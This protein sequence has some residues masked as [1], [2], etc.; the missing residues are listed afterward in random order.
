MNILVIY[1]K[2][3]LTGSF[4]SSIELVKSAIHLKK[5]IRLLCIKEN[6]SDYIPWEDYGLSSNNFIESTRCTILIKDILKS[7]LPQNII[8]SCHSV[9]PLVKQLSEELNVNYSVIV[10]GGSIDSRKSLSA[11]DTY[12]LRQAYKIGCVANH[13]SL[14]IEQNLGIAPIL[15]R[16]S[17]TKACVRNLKLTGANIKLLFVGQLIERKSPDMLR[18]ILYYLN[19]NLG[20][21][22]SITLIGKGP[23][24]D[25][26]LSK[27]SDLAQE[28]T[29][30]ANLQP[31][32]LKKVFIKNDFLVCFSKN[33]GRP[34]VVLEAIAH[35]LIPILSNIP[36]HIEI[37][38]D[39]NQD[40]LFQKGEVGHICKLIKSHHVNQK[41]FVQKINSLQRSALL[42]TSEEFNLGVAQFLTQDSDANPPQFSW[43]LQ[44]APKADSKMDTFRWET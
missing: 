27:I 39:Q 11:K 24:Q 21:K 31:R 43:G 23:E 20:M 37:L 42:E 19:Q 4:L 5:P 1:Y 44:E 18:E 14:Y 22:V 35:G 29:F 32:E 17:F 40:L 2:G 41:L 38:G 9:I 16:H 7:V 25:S 26:I 15:L 12:Y 8:A 34:R 3:Y 13:L 10:R 36:A 33:E 6:A 28:I 30:F